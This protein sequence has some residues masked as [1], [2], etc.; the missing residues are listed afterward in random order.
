MKFDR[1]K[2]FDGSRGFLKRHAKTLT[3]KR[4][5]ALEFLVSAFEGVSSWSLE[6]IA[7]A[8]ATV[9][10]ETAWTFEPI[11]EYG[12]KSYFNKYDGR[13]DL[14]NIYPGDGYRF[15]GRGYVQIT[16]RTNYNKYRIGDN[17]EA[18]LDPRT[19]FLIMASGMQ[20]GTFTGKK[21]GDYVNAGKVDYKN[22]R[23][24]INGTDKAQQIAGYAKEFETILRDSKISAAGSANKPAKDSDTTKAVDTAQ[25]TVAAIESPPPNS[26]IAENIVNVGG[27]ASVPQDFVAEEKNVDAPPPT[28]F[29]GKLK[30]QFFTV[31]AFIGG[32]AGL[33]EWLGVQV[34][35]ET[36]DL[37]K[38]VVPVVMSLGFLGF[39]VWFVSEKIIGWKT[40][41]LKAEIATD[42]NRHNLTIKPQ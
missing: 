40:L 9:A 15:R 23:R 32:G 30:T 31:I 17:P 20:N 11:T 26:Q 19:A 29:F 25:D 24:V 3:P 28:G 27:E 38:V 36:V 37:L 22:A 35:P 10:H 5:A 41:K 1:K 42:P 7:Y 39:L 21:L 16:G 6:Q 18:A 13:R 33:K 12:Q 8:L 4:V 14:G 2:F 34:S